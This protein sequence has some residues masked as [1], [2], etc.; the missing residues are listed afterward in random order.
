MKK[1]VKKE[2]EKLGKKIKKTREKLGISQK[3]FAQKLDITNSSLSQYESGDTNIPSQKLVEIAKLLKTTP[4]D[5]LG[6]ETVDTI[7]YTTDRETLLKK[8]IKNTNTL[9]VAIEENINKVENIFVPIF[10]NNLDD[11]VI[12]DIDGKTYE[13]TVNYRKLEEKNLIKKIEFSRWRNEDS[14]FFNPFENIKFYSSVKDI[15]TIATILLTNKNKDRDK[16]DFLISIIANFYFTTRLK[17]KK[18]VYKYDYDIK[19]LGEVYDFL[20]KNDDIVTEFE[21]MSVEDYLEFGEL[22]T[23]MEYNQ[24]M[25]ITV[26]NLVGFKIPEYYF[27]LKRLIELGNEKLDEIRKVLLRELYFLNNNIYS[28]SENE[29]LTKFYKENKIPI[30]KGEFLLIHNIIPNKLELDVFKCYDYYDQYLEE[31]ADMTAENGLTIEEINFP[32]IRKTYYFVI[33]KEHFEELKPLIKLFFYFLFNQN[34]YYNSNYIEDKSLNHK[35]LLVIIDKF[36]ELD[37]ELENLSQ[38]GIKQ[39]LVSDLNKIDKS[40]FKLENENLKITENKMEYL[41]KVEEEG[42]I[43][44][45]KDICPV[46]K[47]KKVSIED[48]LSAFKEL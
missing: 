31:L 30:K 47:S 36:S 43:E 6:V 21:K 3:E 4:N 40:Y 41:Y 28:S 44:F 22:K 18:A 9:T 45:Y 19:S 8:A 13:E 10:K 14:M 29:N 2:L 17:N 24:N 25:K 33:K 35:N 37:L 15:E 39:I 46:S 26:D 23:L 11:I 48:E 12:L 27:K 20:L 42:E 32:K 1:E 16:L 34:K 5:L 7:K 38:E